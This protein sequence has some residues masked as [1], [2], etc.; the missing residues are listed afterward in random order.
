MMMITIITII[1]FSLCILLM[2]ATTYISGKSIK[3]SCGNSLDN[4]CTCSFL[5]KMKCNKKVNQ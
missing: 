1:I 5:E 3:G 4:P 2:I